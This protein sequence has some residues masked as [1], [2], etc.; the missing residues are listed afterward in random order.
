MTTLALTHK[1]SIY[2][3]ILL[4]MLGKM[5]KGS[6]QISLPSGESFAIGNGEGNITAN[7]QI[8][9]KDFFKRCVLFGDIGFGEAYM[10]DDW[11]TDNIVNVIKWFLLNVDMA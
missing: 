1:K 8:K 10:D 3:S 4:N 6:M 5:E 7:I 9:N 2:E 11:D